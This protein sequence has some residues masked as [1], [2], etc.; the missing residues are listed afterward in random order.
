MQRNAGDVPDL[1]K[2]IKKKKNILKIERLETT[3][4]LQ[5]HF[6]SALW[7][8][9]SNL[10][11]LPKLYNSQTEVLLRIGKNSQSLLNP[12]PGSTKNHPKFKPC[13]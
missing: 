12:T 10:C 9:D 6:F 11:F 7:W 3:F 2:K 5:M 8:E 13:V 1:K 4:V